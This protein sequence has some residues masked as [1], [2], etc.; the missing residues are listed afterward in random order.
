MLSQ[1]FRVQ[2][3]PGSGYR[4]VQGFGSGDQVSGFALVMGPG[5]RWVQG[6]GWGVGPRAPDLRAVFSR[7]PWWLLGLG[8][9]AQESGL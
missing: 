6:L 4:W 3:L 5:F 1:G 9:R 7:V 8:F 2:G